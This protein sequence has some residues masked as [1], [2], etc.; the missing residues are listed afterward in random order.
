MIYESGGLYSSREIETEVF[1]GW[2][3]IYGLIIWE[4]KNITA[5]FASDKGIG[6]KL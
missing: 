6:Y 1:V 3:S 5:S 4:S 2:E